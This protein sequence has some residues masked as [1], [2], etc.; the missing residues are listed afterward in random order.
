MPHDPQQ[1][2]ESH[3]T[4]HYHEAH[5]NAADVPV[6]GHYNT[7]LQFGFS[8]SYW[9]FRTRSSQML[10]NVLCA[11]MKDCLLTYFTSKQLKTVLVSHVFLSLWRDYIEMEITYK[12]RSK[13]FSTWKRQDVK[14][15]VLEI[16][17]LFKHFKD[18]RCLLTHGIF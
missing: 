5:V 7:D 10:E 2:H 4:D 3:E 1:W 18:M 13:I 6:N 16:W 12:M 9:V 14:Q 8:V 17:H 11:F 15:Q